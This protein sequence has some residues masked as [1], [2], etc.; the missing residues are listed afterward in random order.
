M[1]ENWVD[2]SKINHQADSDLWA[3]DRTAHPPL[4][5]FFARR[6][7][8]LQSLT[9]LTYRRI[10]RDDEAYRQELARLFFP[11][12]SDP[13]RSATLDSLL[14]RAAEYLVEADIYLASTIELLPHECRDPVLPLPIVTGCK[15]VRDLMGLAFYGEGERLRY[16]ARRKLYLAQL[17]LRIDQSRQVQDGPAHRA[18][19][20]NLLNEGIWKHT[21][22]IHDIAIGYRISPDG[23]SIQYTSRPGEGDKRWD[24]RST[25]VETKVGERAVA[26]DILYYNC[27]F[28][29]AVNPIS[30]EIVDG[31][32][33]VVESLRWQDMRQE[34]S[35]SI[36]SKMIRKGINNPDEISDIIGAMFIVNDNDALNDLLGLL[37]SCLGAS[38]GWRN[39]TD[40]LRDKPAGSSL[41]AYS[42]KSFKVFKGDVDILAADIGGGPAYRYPVEIQI[43][44]LESYLRTVCGV[45]DASHLAL[46]LRQFLFGLVPRILPR[47][48]YGTEWIKPWL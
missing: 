44:T 29:R 6:P 18:D 30:F 48:I 37:D 7:T 5:P 1:L 25:F 12:G 15:D 31:T 16:E 4:D 3:V 33:R 45:H 35:G 11:H 28:K 47:E 41:N 40:T 26:L 36:L 21:K 20:E 14:H 46:K 24:F 13:E 32:H 22:Q 43:Y 2:V 38:L 39:V 42:S 19:F 9:R 23:D 17:L 34:T 8:R 10:L 27:R